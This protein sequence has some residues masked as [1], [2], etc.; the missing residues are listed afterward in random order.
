MSIVGLVAPRRFGAEFRWVL[1]NAAVR[2]LV[3]TIFVFN[4]TFGAHA[5]IW[6]NDIAHRAPTDRPHRAAGP[7][8]QRQPRPV[9]QHRARRRS[10]RR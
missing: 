3:L 7:G 1:H 2:T 9:D 8:R 4:I 10:R 6:G 5:F